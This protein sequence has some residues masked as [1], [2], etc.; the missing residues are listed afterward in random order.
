MEVSVKYGIWDEPWGRQPEP[1]YVTVLKAVYERTRRV[2]EE[3]VI[4]IHG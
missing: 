4:V 3:E 2:V 1:G